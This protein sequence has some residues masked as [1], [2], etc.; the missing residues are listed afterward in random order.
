MAALVPRLGAKLARPALRTVD[1][2]LELV[3][4]CVVGGELGAPTNAILARRAAPAR[5]AHPWPAWELVGP[6][7]LEHRRGVAAGEKPMVHGFRQLTG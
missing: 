5:R 3:Y 6:L 7:M 1:R 2:H 4:S